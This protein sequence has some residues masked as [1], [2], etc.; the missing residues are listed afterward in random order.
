[1]KYAIEILKIDLYKWKAINNEHTA[2]FCTTPNSGSD[3]AIGVSSAKI[4]SLEKAIK[5]LEQNL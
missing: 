1:M 3:S 4:K 5:T 2:I